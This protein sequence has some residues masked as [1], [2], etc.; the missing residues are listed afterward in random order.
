MAWVIEFLPVDG[1]INRGGSPWA[2]SP[3]PTSSSKR[4][5]IKDFFSEK[6][7]QFLL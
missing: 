3:P 5:N 4:R 7:I 1:D 2:V 6:G